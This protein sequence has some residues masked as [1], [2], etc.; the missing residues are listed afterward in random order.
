MSEQ[1]NK[2]ETLAQREKARKDFL[3]LKEMQRKNARDGANEHIAYSGEIKP[4][5]FMQKLA[6]FWDYHKAAIISVAVII[7]A[8]TVI[9]VQCMGRVESDLK[10][11]IYDNRIIPDMYI[12]DIEDYFEDYAEDYNG[13]GKIK[14]TVINCTFGTGTS[15]ADYQLS[16]QNKLQSIIAT[17][18]ETVLFITGD[19]GYDYLQSITNDSEVK[20]LEETGIA[21]KEDFYK[22]ATVKELPIPDGLTLYLRNVNGTFIE[23][24]EDTK[25]S[26]T[27]AQD[28]L[29]ALK[30]EE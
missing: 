6:H 29:K 21:L 14:V 5:T 12:A 23:D 25:I 28:F 20:L 24:N 7:I 19:I 9:C 16:K 1:K 17:D 22:I 26:I 2:S 4:K 3:E 30:G 18:T 13:D 8:V 27:N 15:T 11:V 10:I